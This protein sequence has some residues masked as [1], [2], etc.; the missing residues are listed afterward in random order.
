MRRLEIAAG[1]HSSHPMGWRIGS[2]PL[3]IDFRADN[4]LAV[5]ALFDYREEAN[6]GHA[7]G[8]ASNA[9]PAG[10]RALA[11]RG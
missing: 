9:V 3:A 2:Q 7:V 8:N 11:G 5:P 1:S 4:G 10:Q 6:S